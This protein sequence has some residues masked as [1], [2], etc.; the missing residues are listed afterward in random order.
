M[1]YVPKV[2]MRETVAADIWT[3]FNAPD[4]EGAQR[5]HHLTAEKYRSKASLL[6]SWMEDNIPKGFACFNLS[7]KFRHRL[8]T[9][10]VLER[11][12]KEIKY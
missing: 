10:N 5:F 11:V 9:T 8:R 3:V 2:H 1:A 4:R 6:G 12:H 7:M